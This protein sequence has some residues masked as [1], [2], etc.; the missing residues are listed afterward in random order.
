MYSIIRVQH[1][2]LSKSVSHKGITGGSG[3]TALDFID[4]TPKPQQKIWSTDLSIIE[5]Q[6]FLKRV[7][8]LIISNVMKFISLFID[9]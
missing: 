2:V 5:L 4:D 6:F 8:F 7:V 1:E 3:N 9:I